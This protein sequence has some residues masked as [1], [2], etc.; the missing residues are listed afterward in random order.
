MVLHFSLL[1]IFLVNSNLISYRMFVAFKN[2][3]EN[4][5]LETQPILREVT[6]NLIAKDQLVYFIKDSNIVG[7]VY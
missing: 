6:L 3:K 4:V 1:H 2:S 5:D 7:Y